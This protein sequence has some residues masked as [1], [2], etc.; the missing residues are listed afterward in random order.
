MVKIKWNT[1]CSQTM[2][3]LYYQQ[4]YYFCLSDPMFPQDGGANAL[5]TKKKA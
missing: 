5:L 4:I 3:K 1:S 2:E